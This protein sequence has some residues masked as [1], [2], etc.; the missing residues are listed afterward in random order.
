MVR[1]IIIRLG[2]GIVTVLLLAT[3]VFV[4][5]RIVGNPVHLMLPED[6]TPEMKQALTE[7]LG[8]DQ[9]YYVQYAR[10]F[11]DLLRGDLGQSIRYGRPVAKLYLTHFPNTVKLAA[12]ALAI[13]V[14]FGLLLGVVSA[15]RRDTFIDHFAR[16]LSVIGMSVPKFWLGLMLALVFSH[17]LGILP[18]ARM[19]SP[20]SYILPGF[21]WSF[22]ILAGISR[23]VRSSMLEVLDSEYVKL[24]RIK[25][26]TWTKIVWKHCLKNAVLPVYTFVGVYLAFLLG[27]SV[28]IEAVFAW[29]GVGRLMYQ[30]ILSRDYPLIQGC[31][32]MLGCIIVLISL[33]IDI[34]YAY[35]DPRIRVAGGQ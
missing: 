10:Y 14:L 19:T 17:W 20:A 8:L 1:Y 22:F 7:R 28:V 24:A 34:S 12:V 13:A 9:P 33:V 29:P 21:T 2:H 31:V 16:M 5:S 25:G 4:L 30:A 35:I 18:S 27:G 26:V 3:M 32:L 6:A 15:T 23:I 11:W